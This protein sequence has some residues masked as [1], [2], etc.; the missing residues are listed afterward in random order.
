M[1]IDPAVSK[2]VGARSDLD[3][4][5]DF[6]DML[7][8]VVEA[9][10]LLACADAAGLLLRGERDVLVWAGASDPRAERAE[11]VQTRLGAGPSVAAWRERGPVAVRDVT[12][13]PRWREV[14]RGFVAAEVRAALSVPVELEGGPIGTLD[15]YAAAP[16]D[17]ADGEIAALQAYA[18]VV[19]SLLRSAVGASVKGGLAKQLQ[20]ALN[21]RMVIEQAKGVLM[22]REGLSPSAAFERLRGAARSVGRTVG[23]VAG[24]VLAGGGLPPRPAHRPAGASPPLPVEET[25]SGSQRSP[26]VSNGP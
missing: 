22:E 15:V 11:A 12:A 21:H 24:M 19:A 10:K 1:R 26:T 7:Q 5:A 2:S 6:G 17:W 14:T 23:E 13:D 16:R 9:A 18:G 8:R 20:W 25:S 3:V 4:A